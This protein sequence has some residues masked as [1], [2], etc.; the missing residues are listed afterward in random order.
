MHHDD[1]LPSRLSD[2][3]RR[4]PDEMR[5]FYQYCWDQAWRDYRDAG[6]P[7]GATKQGFRQWLACDQYP[8]VN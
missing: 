6:A 1:H 2:P 7:F 5:Q 4:S 3:C 8:T